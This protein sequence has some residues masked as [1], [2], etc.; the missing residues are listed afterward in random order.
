[1]EQKSKKTDI[2]NAIL[3]GGLVLIWFALMV[4]GVIVSL[5]YEKLKKMRE[6]EAS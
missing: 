2:R 3:L 6:G 1:M 5:P 4:I